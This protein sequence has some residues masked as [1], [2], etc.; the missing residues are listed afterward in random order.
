MGAVGG[1]L[2][3]DASLAL[4]RHVLE[5]PGK[6][7]RRQGQRCMAQ[8]LAHEVVA[9]QGD[10]LGGGI[11]VHVLVCKRHKERH[12]TQFMGRQWRRPVSPHGKRHGDWVSCRLMGML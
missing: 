6:A 9:Y 2:Q 5:G 1:M 7:Y 8:R 11:A 10:T 4:S 3:G 12:V